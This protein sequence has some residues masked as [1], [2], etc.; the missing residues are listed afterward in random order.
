MNHCLSLIRYSELVLSAMVRDDGYEKPLYLEE[1]VVKESS[2]KAID[3]E[4]LF[5][6]QFNSFA[7]EHKQS[8]N[9][10]SAILLGFLDS[11]VVFLKRWC[12]SLLVKPALD[13]ED[14][15]KWSKLFKVR[16]QSMSERRAANSVMSDWMADNGK[17]NLAIEDESKKIDL[18]AALKDIV[19]FIGQNCPQEGSDTEEGG[20]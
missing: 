3:A 19:V 13:L 12:Y 18:E 14:V 7:V 4:A 1:F 2:S 17:K 11:A 20:P 5:V 10:R 9:R 15:K 8:E 16:K 6:A